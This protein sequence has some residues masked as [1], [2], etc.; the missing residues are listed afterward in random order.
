M[1]TIT[2][3]LD[4]SLLQS[5]LAGTLGYTVR[6]VGGATLIART[7]AGISEDGT[8]ANYWV[9]VANWDTSWAGS[10]VWDAGAGTLA[11]EAF[12]A[13]TPQTGDAY[14][15]I[16][17]AGAGLTALGDARL[18][19]LDADVSSRS[20]HSAADVWTSTTRILTAFTFPVTAA[21]VTDKSGYSLVVAPPTAAD[22]DT[23]LSGSHGAG[24]WG[25]GLTI[26]DVQ[27][28]LTNQGYTTGRA[29]KLDN[30]DVATST[31]L[32]TAGYTAPPTDYQPRNVAVTLPTTPPTGYGGATAAAIVSALLTTAVTSRN[33]TTVTAPTIMDAMAASVALA[34]GRQ[35]VFGVAYTLLALDG[36]I[37]RSFTLTV[38]PGDQARS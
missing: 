25:G 19:H 6:G 30:A 20:S 17:A 9:D 23:Q 11:R 4:V 13:Y 37:L 3:R 16:G 32:A 7:T 12:V 5:G 35:S 14:A 15:R 8:S 36:T 27:T 26:T 18:A 24:D 29:A 10:V 34:A 28:A 21:S 2:R 31:R 1:P 33:L 38:A 22:I